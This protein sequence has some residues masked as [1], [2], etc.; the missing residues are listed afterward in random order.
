MNRY[1]HSLEIKE[2]S[3]LNVQNEVIQVVTNQGHHSF[4]FEFALTGKWY[5]GGTMA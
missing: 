4:G 2:S 5:M 1:S 3:Y